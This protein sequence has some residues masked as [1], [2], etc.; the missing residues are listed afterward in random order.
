MIPSMLL[1]QGGQSVNA[2]LHDLHKFLEFIK[3]LVHYIL[4]LE[5]KKSTEHVIAWGVVFGAF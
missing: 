3:I 5:R 1:A 2:Y 4:Y